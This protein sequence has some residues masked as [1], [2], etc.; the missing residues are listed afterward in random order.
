MADLARWQRIARDADAGHAAHLA[1]AERVAR[2]MRVVLPDECDCPGCRQQRGWSE[3]KGANGQAMQLLRA[4]LSPAQREQLD[5]HGYF[6][7]RG[8]AGGRYRVHTK[9]GKYTAGNVAELSGEDGVEVARFC[10]HGE[11]TRYPPA[12]HFL[13]QKLTIEADER[14]FVSVAYP[15]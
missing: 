3:G 11:D 13:L 15:W 5:K 7:V 10:A 4:C 9:N 1:A 12:D 8:S 2:A 6:D 14:A